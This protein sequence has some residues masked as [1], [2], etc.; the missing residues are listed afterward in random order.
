VDDPQDQQRRVLIGIGA[1]AAL[2]AVILA[3]VVITGNDDDP[4]ATTT[5]SSSSSTPTSTSTTSSTAP[6]TSTTISAA[7]LD[8]TVFPDLTRSTPFTDPAEMV[9]SFATQVLGFDT[10]VVVGTLRQGDARSGEFA[11]HPKG[12]T[13][14]TTV[15][16]RQISDGSWVVLGASTDSIRLD[17]P[18]AGSKISSPQ[19]LLGAAYAFE[20][21]VDV[22]LYAD[23]QETAI[24]NTFVMGRGD[25]VLGR[26]D[27]P[28][29][30]AV[31]PGTTRGVLVLSSANGNDGTTVAAVAIRV[32]F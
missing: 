28:F 12:S 31:P 24:A 3:I 8:A 11:V 22:T 27:K 5:T 16:V 21:T 32:R 18:I 15:P 13:A 29:T 17:T 7:D 10:D 6:P 2:V 9:A 4:V 30:F 19:P 20:G 26:F 1:V 23:G 25:G 14:T